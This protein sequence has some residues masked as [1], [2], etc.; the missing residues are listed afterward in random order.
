VPQPFEFSPVKLVYGGEALGFHAGHTVLSPLVL[1]N[2]T[3]L[4][5]ETRRQKSIIFARPLKILK[6]APERIE[7]QCQY[8][9]RCGGCHYQH[10][11][12]ELQLATKTEILRETLRRLGQVRW[13]GT[14][15]AHSGPAWNYR[16]QA[17]FKIGKSSEGTPS[18]GFYEAGS[19][20]LVSIGMCPILSPRLNAL[21]AIL[22][23]E[24]W[25]SQIA[26]YQE[27]EL[28]A[29]PRDEKV[30]LTIHGARTDDEGFA[31]RCLAELDGVST[32]AFVREEHI[33][34]FGAQHLT[35]Q[36]GEF[37]YRVSP[38]AFFQ[39]ARF[40]L[41]EFLT[42]VT[43]R[44]SGAVAMDLYAGVGLFTLPL[45][46]KFDVVLAAEAA[47]YAAEDL[48]A[49]ARAVP[50]KKIRVSAGTAFDFLRRSAQMN[51]D[52]VIVDPPRAGMDAD[53]LKLLIALKPKRI[54]YVSCAPPTLARDLGILVKNGYQ[55]D[56]L[57][58]FDLFPQT[59]HIEA[60]ARLSPIG[61][62]SA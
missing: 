15:T 41:P 8:F 60:L 1:P 12:P 45:A 24:P 36:V 34:V 35:Y 43:D 54:H 26:S 23:T 9:G 52:L 17:Q 32:V 40:L 58:M 27:L 49:N 46:T 18:L 38:T 48:A 37:A 50:G 47:R 21:L 51:P 61:T 33:K 53:T 29:D 57:E 4:V 16:N 59:Y 25:L 14:I 19:N 2:E 28:L 55:L 39:S 20:R 22:Q 10:L 6:P 13:E 62:K 3:A 44:V 56:S 42:A 5:E 30:M 7:P 31:Q 11:S